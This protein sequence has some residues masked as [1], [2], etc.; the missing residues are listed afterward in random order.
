MAKHT[1]VEVRRDST[2]TQT[3]G[4]LHAKYFIVDGRDAYLGSQN[5]DWRALEHIQELGL[6]VRM[7]TVVEWL[8]AVFERD[9]LSASGRKLGLVP[10]PTGP[11][12]KALDP[13]GNAHVAPV[14]SP[15]GPTV[16]ASVWDLPRLIKMIGNA[17]ASVRV[18]LL[19]YRATGRDGAY[20]ADLETALRAA[21]ARGVQVQMLLADWCKR[22]PT[23]KGLQSLQCLPN[24]DVKLVTIPEWSGGF[25]PFARVVHAKYL[26]VDGHAAWLGT[27]NWERDYFF[28]SRNVGVIM[29]G[30]DVPARLDEFFARMWSC[31]YVELV[32]PGATYAAPRI[33]E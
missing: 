13:D 4:V 17:R 20:F 25:I 8:I 30:G 14:F 2:R 18:Q 5:F 24:L 23:I 19:T 10:H 26:V 12:S 6:R 21:A 32:D 11:I 15:Q 31:E 28:N 9:W 29:Q 22:N 7:P 33:R 3:G 16:S 1:N 27:S